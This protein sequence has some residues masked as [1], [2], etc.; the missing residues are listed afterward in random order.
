MSLLTL[1]AVS[2]S[3][4]PVP[5]LR[6]VSLS[7]DEGEAVAVVGPNGAGKSTLT[8]AIAG[9]IRSNAGEIVFAGKFDQGA[10]AEAVARKGVALVPEGRHIFEGLTVEENLLL[11]TT[12][13][14]RDASQ[15]DVVGGSLR[16]VPHLG[17]AP[18]WLGDESCPAANS[19]NGDRA[20]PAL[21]TAPAIIDEPSLGLSPVMIIRSRIRSSCRPEGEGCDFVARGTECR[22]NSRRCG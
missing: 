4:G 14:P 6:Q 19:S 22:P 20:R 8:L 9:V 13:R 21:A 1:N 12:A 2:S 10:R 15:A 16:I 11:G 18:I 17:R 5:A 3:Y 7:V